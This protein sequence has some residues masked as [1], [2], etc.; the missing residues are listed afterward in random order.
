[1]L[2]RYVKPKFGRHPQRRKS[3][4]AQDGLPIGEHN[5]KTNVV[6][7]SDELCRNTTRPMFAPLEIGVVKG[8]R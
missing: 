5:C 4:L 2:S 7:A 8:P 3:D 6:Y 1:M